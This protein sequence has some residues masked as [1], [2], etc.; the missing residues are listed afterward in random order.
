QS[1][2]PSDRRTA[3]SGHRQHHHMAWQL[4]APKARSSPSSSSER[5]AASLNLKRRARLAGADG[6]SAV[7][8]AQMYRVTDGSPS[9]RGRGQRRQQERRFSRDDSGGK[10]D[11]RSSIDA[12]Q[13]PRSA[14]L[15]TAYA[16]ASSAAAAMPQQP[17]SSQPRIPSIAEGIGGGVVT[18]GDGRPALPLLDEED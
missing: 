1:S 14:E 7:S 10:E 16:S 12:L 11:G 4:F 15:L 8:P 6:V 17:S 9:G 13:S 2:L 3:A 18:Q 5:A